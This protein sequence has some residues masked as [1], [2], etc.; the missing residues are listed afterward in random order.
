LASQFHARF[1]GARG[2]GE[3]QASGRAPVSLSGPSIAGEI[4]ILVERLNSA[5]A[6]A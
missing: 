6:H 4:E 1:Q 3:R 2:L 5:L